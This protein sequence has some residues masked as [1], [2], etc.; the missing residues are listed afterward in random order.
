MYSIYSKVWWFGP[1]MYFVPCVSHV[2]LYAYFFNSRHNSF[3]GKMAPSR[4]LLNSKA[5]WR[6]EPNLPE[7]LLREH[8]SNRSPDFE[9]P[10]LNEDEGMSKDNKMNV[11]PLQSFSQL[12]SQLLPVDKDKTIKNFLAS[13]PSLQTIDDDQGIGENVYT[14]ES[15]SGS[16]SP[17][18]TPTDDEQFHLRHRLVK[19]IKDERCSRGRRG[20]RYTEDMETGSSPTEMSGGYY[21]QTSSQVT[22]R[23]PSLTQSYSGIP[24]KP[25][26]PATS[27]TTKSKISPPPS[28]SLSITTPMMASVRQPIAQIHKYKLV[29]MPTKATSVP[30]DLALSHNFSA[31]PSRKLAAIS[32]ES[33]KTSLSSLVTSALPEKEGVEEADNQ[34]E[35][36][37][38]I[39]VT[40]SKELIVDEP[41]CE[42][43]SVRTK[44][45][46]RQSSDGALPSMTSSSTIAT[47]TASDAGNQQHRRAKSD[48]DN[49][50]SGPTQIPSV[51]DRVKE[52]EEMSGALS[53]T[54]GGSSVTN[55]GAPSP[56]GIYMNITPN[57]DDKQPSVT[58]SSVSDD[59]QQSVESMSQS[60]SEQSL[61]SDSELEEIEQTSIKSNSPRCMRATRHGSLSPNPPSIQMK[62][63]TEQTRCTSLM[64]LPHSEQEQ[65]QQTSELNDENLASSLMGAVKARIQDIEE[66]NKDSGGSSRSKASPEKNEAFKKSPPPAKVVQRPSS[67]A[68]T[69]SANGEQLDTSV[70]ALTSVRRHSTTT[71]HRR[72]SS[73]VLVEDESRSQ[74][75]AKPR[76]G[77]RESTPPA[78]F[79]A[80]SQLMPADDIPRNPVQDLKQK[81]EESTESRTVTKSMEARPRARALDT[82]KK[83]GSNL[84]R[85]Q[86][87]RT[88]GSP[89][90]SATKHGYK[91]K[92]PSLEEPSKST[93]TPISDSTS[94]D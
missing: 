1:L 83:L 64:Y 35:D 67:S 42:E 52:I 54:Q 2:L 59:K 17:I 23:V 43:L 3:W 50:I 8:R 85:S 18:L 87:L 72:P 56:G 39:T 78:L 27:R 16:S 91:R 19:E 37:I 10:F 70:E 28:D 34:P 33:S 68:V 4:P 41:A 69:S 61:S 5:R 65:H 76:M 26:P 7:C 29:P 75:V 63:V 24:P 20:K 90:N 36:S 47:E 51:P 38:M 57:S 15:G 80:W 22:E 55:S 46:A 88:V 60:S 86:S 21:S 40:D 9:L 45:H 6:S 11:I 82:I 71:Q 32:P 12:P 92:K 13:L 49:N 30:H 79:S 73:E 14:S 31:L 94:Q 77:R 81:F 66:K 58:S 89:S 74:S 53:S 93:F 48:G 44:E 62:M 84:R 25:A